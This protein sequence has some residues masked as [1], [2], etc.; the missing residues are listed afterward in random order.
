MK[1]FQKILNFKTRGL[2]DF[3]RITEKVEEV[4]KESKISNGIVFLNSLH[5]TAALL[6]QENDP[7]IHEDLINA[8]ERVAPMSGKYK[9][10]YEGNENATAHIK[11]NLLESN[12]TLPIKDGK[13]LLGTWQDIFLVE[14]FESRERKVVLTIIGD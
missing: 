8:F 12:I 2:N 10:D 13:L 7:T 9:H 11:T 1:I 3:V 5:N 6:I 14:F 4:V